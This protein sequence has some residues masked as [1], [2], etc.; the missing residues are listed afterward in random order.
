MRCSWGRPGKKAWS[1]LCC[2]L[3]KH[4]SCTLVWGSWAAIELEASVCNIRG[5][6]ILCH[7]L[8]ASFGIGD[9]ESPQLR[10]VQGA[11]SFMASCSQ[12]GVRWPRVVTEI[13]V[14]CCSPLWKC[15]S[16][17]E[18]IFA[19][20]SC[21]SQKSS[22]FALVLEH[23]HMVLH[24]APRQREWSLQ[25][26]QALQELVRNDRQAGLVSEVNALCSRHPVHQL[27]GFASPAKPRLLTIK[28]HDPSAYAPVCALASPAT[29]GA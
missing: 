11:C 13:R 5:R 10:K 18:H 2:T 27:K 24:A 15:F 6:G 3:S 25:G 16:C 17:L 7:C 20:P 1:R 4:A 26:R 28:S 14:S 29:A 19:W 12:C 9:I 21:C 23:L 22:I 8:S